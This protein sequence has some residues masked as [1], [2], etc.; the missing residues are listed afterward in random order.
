MLEAKYTEHHIPLL[1]SVRRSS[2]KGLQLWFSYLEFRPSP[3]SEYGSL[4]FLE[5]LELSD[6]IFFP[7][8]DVVPVCFVRIGQEV[9]SVPIL[10]LGSLCYSRRSPV[11]D[12]MRTPLGV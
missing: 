1:Y 3:C 7:S 2:L 6:Q 8:S 4:E 12:R 11:H 5:P 10:A 9:S